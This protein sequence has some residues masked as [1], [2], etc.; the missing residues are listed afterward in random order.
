MPDHPLSQ[1]VDESTYVQTSEISAVMLTRT[2]PT[3]TRTRI[4]ATR[5]RTRPARTRT[6]TGPTRT[7]TRT[8]T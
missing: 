7:R 6:K 1:T 8:R 5:T 4:R 2:G 3:R